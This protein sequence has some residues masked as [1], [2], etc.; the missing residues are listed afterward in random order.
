MPELSWK[1]RLFQII[2]GHIT[3][4]WESAQ[5]CWMEKSPFL[6]ARMR[7]SSA[8]H[9]RISWIN[10][11]GCYMNSLA[12]RKYEIAVKRAFAISMAIL[13]GVKL[14]YVWVMHDTWVIHITGYSLLIYAISASFMAVYLSCLFSILSTKVEVIQ[15]IKAE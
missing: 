5:R 4:V 13:G 14:F 15:Y 10:M 11:V 3:G 7:S 2:F 12:K 6:W 8:R 9:F 1:C